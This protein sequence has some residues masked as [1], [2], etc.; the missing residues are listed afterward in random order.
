VLAACSPGSATTPSVIF[1][2]T[3]TF[4]VT[5]SF[6][7]DYI[8]L[9]VVCIVTGGLCSGY[10]S[11]SIL[12]GTHFYTLSLG[13]GGGFFELP[14]YG[15]GPAPGLGPDC[16]FYPCPEGGE[17]LFAGN[18]S[19]HPPG[20]TAFQVSYSVDAIDNDDPLG[21]QTAADTITLNICLQPGIGPYCAVITAPTYTE[22][23]SCFDNFNPTTGLPISC[24]EV[25]VRPGNI[26]P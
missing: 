17:A 16:F 14:I 26:G 15:T 8:K 7:A 23:F 6:A 22:T 20:Q 12:G 2:G 19:F 5:T 9:N 21:F 24:F 10:A 3:E 18:A 11:G 25:T 13:G 1:G 4:P